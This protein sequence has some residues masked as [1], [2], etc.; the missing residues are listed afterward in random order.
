MFAAVTRL[1]TILYNAIG[2]DIVTKNV[3]NIS[4]HV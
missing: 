3:Y 2:I 4:V 1:N